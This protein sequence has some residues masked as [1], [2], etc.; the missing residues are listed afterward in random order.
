MSFLYDNCSPDGIT[1]M[2]VK[3]R[4]EQMIMPNDL[5]FGSTGKFLLVTMTVMVFAA[6]QSWGSVPKKMISDTLTFI[7]SEF[8][9]N[10]R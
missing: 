6:E 1:G 10:C 2:T 4:F 3:L 5:R 8:C 7:C 9:R